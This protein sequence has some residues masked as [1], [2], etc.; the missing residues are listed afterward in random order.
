VAPP[1]R[2]DPS[3]AAG[4]RDDVD[5]FKAGLLWLGSATL[6]TRLLSVG[7][8]LVVLA[9]LTPED[10]GLAA[11]AWS[12]GVVVE[13]FNGLGVGS[14]L[15]Q[16]SKEGVDDRHSLWWF[17]TGLG[18][19]LCLVMVALGPVFAAIYDEPELIPMMAVSGLKMIFVG[20]AVV[21]IHILMKRL[22]FKRSAA[23]QSSATFLESITKIAL[24]ATG[25]G[26]WA[27]VIANVARG[28]FAW[29]A[30]RV[31]CPYRVRWA[32]SWSVLKPYIAF[33]ARMSGSRALFHF[34]RNADYFIVGK[35]FGVDLLG[36]YKV[37]YE[38][39]MT[40]TEAVLQVVNRVAYPVF[41]RIGAEK[42]RVVA[43]FT[44]IARSL[45]FLTGTMAVFLFFAAEDLIRLI[46]HDGWLAAVPAIQILCW[47]GMLRGLA[48]LFPELVTAAGRPGLALVDGIISMVVLVGA[49]TV[50][51]LAFGDTLGIEAVC[52][53]WVVSYPVII[54]FLVWLARGVVP[55]RPGPL[56]AATGG[57]FGGVA[58]VGLALFGAATLLATLGAPPAAT[59]PLLAGVGIGT[60]LAYARVA[61]GVRP[62]DV[63]PRREELLESP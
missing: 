44:H 27:L 17:A 36:I 39:A 35:V 10:I 57:A 15:V 33:G 45:V 19:A 16:R 50:A 5:Q 62:R 8:T 13:A 29:L 38:I 32:F 26:A 11:L 63:L 55:L 21:P 24:A 2:P 37:A 7:A 4:H 30:A 56:L 23:V 49:F 18:V 58:C 41:A 46:T 61:L 20:A 6:L 34:Y 40:P 48:Q 52:W 12:V 60:L 9:F 42:D 3:G 59:V 28:A 22:E 43:A 54:V 47:G 53:A 14:A 25:L 31:F 51:A 1:L